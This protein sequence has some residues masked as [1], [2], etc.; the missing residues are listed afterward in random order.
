[1]FSGGDAWTAASHDLSGDFLPLRREISTGP[2]ASDL[3]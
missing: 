3:G 1:M 2:A